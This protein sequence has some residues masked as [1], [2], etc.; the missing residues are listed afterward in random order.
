MKKVTKYHNRIRRMAVGAITATCFA[1]LLY[2]P[3]S[4]KNETEAVGCYKV[5]MN[6]QEI[7]C[8]N[9][10]E[11][12]KEAYFSARKQLSLDNDDVVYANMNFEVVE[13]AKAF[14]KRSSI[15]DMQQIMYESLSANVLD[16]DVEDGYTV[17]INDFT[18][19]VASKEDVV[20]LIEKVKSPYDGNNVFQVGMV[21]NNDSVGYSVELSKSGFAGSDKELVAMSQNGNA[22]IAESDAEYDGLGISSMDFCQNISITKT[23]S[24]SILSVEEAVAEVTK[25]TASKTYYTVIAGD[26]LSAIARKNNLTMNELLALNPGMTINSYILP[27]DK[28]VVTV[29]KPELS[30]QVVERVTED[31]AYY[32]PVVYRDNNSMYVGNYRE[33]SPAVAGTRTVIADITYVDGVEASRQ[34]VEESITKEAVAQVVE[35][36]TL[37][38]PT[39]IKPISGGSVTYTFG[40]HGSNFH[41]GN[42]WYVS[43]G[44]PIMACASGTVIRA[45]W[46]NGYGNCVEVR[47]DN[48]VVTRYAHLSGYNCGVGQ[49][50]GQGQVIAYSGATG[51][52]TGPHIHLEFIIN[53]NFADPLSYVSR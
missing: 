24:T 53:G 12:A 48:G 49:R 5:I 8:V 46:Y 34:I 2:V 18:V 20:K 17:R 37:V 40:W 47:H 50:V 51:N 27:G 28:L 35:R 38:P 36:G 15:S 44:T 31:E 16:M 42:D 6:G 33:I 9:S 1:C 45:S 11:D 13:D 4:I 52:V 10:P 43:V 29:P 21:A 23:K 7:G 22:V 26:C 39:Y 25:T 41:K 32:A 3:M 14:G 30:V 19:T